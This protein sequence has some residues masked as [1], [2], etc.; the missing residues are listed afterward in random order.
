MIVAKP[1]LDLIADIDAAMFCAAKP[2]RY[3]VWRDW[4]TV[5]GI[6]LPKPL[7][8]E[9]VTRGKPAK[10][11]NVAGLVPFSTRHTHT[12]SHSK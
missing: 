6:A 4:L 12:K 1:S 5:N 2:E 8:R 3:R 7:P 9:F 10:L 11:P